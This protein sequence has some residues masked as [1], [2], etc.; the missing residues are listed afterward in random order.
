MRG[1]VACGLICDETPRMKTPL[2]GRARW[3]GALASWLAWS[4]C[5]EGSLPNAETPE[6]PAPR[7]S[8]PRPND[9]TADGGLPYDMRPAS[10]MASD[11]SADQGPV[12]TPDMAPDMRSPD[13]RPADPCAGLEACALGTNRCEG[14]LIRSCASNRDGCLVFEPAVA[15]PPS[16]ACREGDCRPVSNCIDLD[17]DGYGQGCALGPDCRDDNPAIN[18]GATEVCDGVDNNCNSLI[19]EGFPGVGQAC[20]A[21]QGACR[22]MGTNICGPNGQVVCDATPGQPTMEVCDGVDNDCNGIV[23]DGM[24]CP[25]PSCASD[26]QEPNETLAQA[27]VVNTNAAVLGRTCAGDKEFFRLNVTPGRSHRVNLAFPHSLSDLDLILYEDGQVLRRSDSA[28]DHEMITFTPVAGRTYTAEVV[29][30]GGRDAF[31]RFSVID[32]WSCSSE[33]AFERNDGISVTNFL[34]AGWRIPLYMCSNN[35]DWFYLD[36]VDAGKT[37]TINAYFRVSFL[38]GSGDLDL[39]LYGDDNNDGTYQLLKSATGSGSNETLTH[40]TTYRGRYAVVVR[41]FLAASSRL[42]SRGGLG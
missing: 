19:D 41:G 21:G 16:T 7:P 15:C 31:Y 36:E 2:R 37:I 14:D 27:F 33:D 42:A 1:D 30:F 29:N 22:A 39:F 25:T 3:I 11:L 10:D 20:T 26:P 18:P 28:S 40:L 5:V 9:P 17:G 35:D 32:A 6:E 38:L 13:M 24:V 8:V 4:G 12:V 34:P 23:D